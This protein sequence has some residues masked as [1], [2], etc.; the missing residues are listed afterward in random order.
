M[1]RVGIGAFVGVAAVALGTMGG[2]AL[3]QDAT[4]GKNVWLS[5][6]NCADC[7]GWFGDGNAEDPR[8]PRGANLR[9]T[10]L[11]KDSLIEIILCGIPGTSM[12]HFDIKA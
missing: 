8:S 6:A 11:D 9:E 3:A 7:H 12:P 2:P 5:Q 10:E 4:F 1:I